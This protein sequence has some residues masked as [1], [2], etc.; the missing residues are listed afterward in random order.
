MNSK[1]SRIQSKESYGG[2]GALYIDRGIH[3]D[4]GENFQ[5]DRTILNMD[6]FNKG[7]SAEIPI[8]KNLS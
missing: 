8:S 6:V 3:N 5:E 1:K 4:K 7:A 2:G